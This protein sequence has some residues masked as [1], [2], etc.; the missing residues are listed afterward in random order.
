MASLLNA[1][2]VHSL[3]MQ[4]PRSYFE[5]GGR[6]MGA[7]Y[8][9]SVILYNFQKSGGRGVGADYTFSVIL[10]NFQKSGGTEA[11]QAPPPPRALLCW[12]VV[13]SSLINLVAKLYMHLHL[14]V[15]TPNSINFLAGWVLSHSGSHPWFYVRWD[16]GGCLAHCFEHYTHFL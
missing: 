15:L 10:Y 1:S 12:L 5:S 6:G 8:T 2:I 14:F 3:V 7:D 11:P 13:S 9:F 4:V 16:F